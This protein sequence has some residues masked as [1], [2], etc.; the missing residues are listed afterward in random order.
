MEEVL[1]G[2]ALTPQ[3]AGLLL[4]MRAGTRCPFPRTGL[5]TPLAS[6]KSQRSEQR[7]FLRLQADGL[8]RCFHGEPGSNAVPHLCR[9]L[10]LTLTTSCLL[11]EGKARGGAGVKAAAGAPVPNLQILV[12]FLSVKEGF[13]NH[14]DLKL[15]QVLHLQ[16]QSQGAVLPPAP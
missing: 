15:M 3:A 11:Q 9:L 12:G 7:L 6:V 13:V 4:R 16:A 14:M 5:L 8:R 10:F 1:A 2:G